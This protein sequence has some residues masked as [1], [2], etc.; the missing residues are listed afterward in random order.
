[1]NSFLLCEINCLLFPPWLLLTEVPVS[2]NGDIGE[3]HHLHC[4]DSGKF[5]RFAFLYFIIW[6]IL[7]LRS[8]IVLIFLFSGPASQMR[9]FRCLQESELILFPV[10]IIHHYVITY[11]VLNI[12]HKIH[13]C[14]W[15]I[16]F[17]LLCALICCITRE[18]WL[19]FLRK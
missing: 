19:T 2:N 5:Y 3:G 6:F 14:C 4:H 12:V 1:M 8:G 16:V 13:G 9:G 17:I 11:S 18:K 10:M 7:W 15:E